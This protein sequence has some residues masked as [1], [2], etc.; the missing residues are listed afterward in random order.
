MTI[1]LVLERSR[2]NLLKTPDVEIDTPPLTTANVVP[3]C[4][5]CV[6]AMESNSR[7]AHVILGCISRSDRTVNG[8]PIP[9]S[10]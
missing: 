5:L 10:I 7:G 2:V 1:G 8:L 3:F 4:D 6:A 9:D